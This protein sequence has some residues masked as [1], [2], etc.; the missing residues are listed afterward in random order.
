MPKGKPKKS[1]E[2]VVDANKDI[3]NISEIVTP[4]NAISLVLKGLRKE[5]GDSVVPAQE[6]KLEFDK[7]FIKDNIISTGNISLDHMTGIGGIPT[8]RIIEVYGREGAG[9]TSFCVIL[10]AIAQMA[11]MFVLYIDAEHRLDL[12]Y[13]QQ[14]GL[15][16]FDKEKFAPVRPNNSD[17]VFRVIDEVLSIGKPCAI[18]VD[19]VPAILPKK[20]ADIAWGET[21]AMA[22]QAL[23][24]N[25]FLQ[26]CNPKIAKS[27]SLFLFTN[28]LRAK[29]AGKMGFYK[30]TTGGNALPYYSTL[31][32]NIGWNKKTDIITDADGNQ[33]GAIME[34]AFDKTNTSA[35]PKPRKI[36]FKFGSGF[37]NEM[38][39]VEVGIMEQIIKKAG[40]W[41][42]YKL[43]NE[44]IRG[45][46][47]FNFTNLVEENP[48]LYKAIIREIKESWGMK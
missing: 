36:C 8:G 18:I 12:G 39:V 32:I 38:Q 22:R 24:M 10:S 34:F 29:S 47:K 23:E 46:G 41:L 19:S 2:V 27:Q 37:W 15:N 31:R 26:R 48:K 43:D 33:L 13:A 6:N 1:K 4:T 42:S 25:E 20:K 21:S 3:G 5:F 11:G 45:Q 17:H 40:A 9:K 44:E 28:Q 16:I 30:G 35:P 14:L 7:L